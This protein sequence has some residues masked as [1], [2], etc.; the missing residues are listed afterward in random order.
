MLGAMLLSGAEWQAVWLSLRV[1]LA[2]VVVGVVPAL[3]V[4]WVLARKEFVGKGVVEVLV[5]LPLVLPPV[6]T[7]YLL[8]VGFG[9]N[10]ILGRVLEGWLGVQVVFTWKAAAIAS[11]VMGF[12]LMVG[13]MRVA[14]AGVDRRLEDAA[15]TL[16]AGRL[17]AFATVTLPLAWHGVVAGVV[18]GFARSMGEFGATIMVAGSIPGQT[19]T[20]PLQ[21]YSAIQSPGGVERARA[22]V[23]V[24]VVIAA[25]ALVVGGWLERRGRR[26]G[27]RGA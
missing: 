21:I 17:R 23:V 19:R 26:A 7:G 9:R 8:L 5:M 18:L 14:I 13:A 27:K 24:A 20:I 6:V 3:A 4:A 25:A 22:M 11:G 2:A 16:G 10:G 15:R 12:P 1:A